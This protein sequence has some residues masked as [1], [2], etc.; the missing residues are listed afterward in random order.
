MRI[1]RSR[2]GGMARTP[3]DR[4][5]TPR[6]SGA[7]SVLRTPSPNR[8][9]R[10]AS[11]ESA[12]ALPNRDGQVDGE[13]QLNQENQ[14]ESPT[15]GNSYQH[16]SSL[17]ARKQR[18]S[19]KTCPPKRKHKKIFQREIGGNPKLPSRHSNQSLLSSKSIPCITIPEQPGFSRDKNFMPALHSW[20]GNYIPSL[21]PPTHFLWTNHTKSI[22]KRPIFKRVILHNNQGHPYTPQQHPG[23]QQQRNQ[24]QILNPF[25]QV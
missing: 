8:A 9:R 3:M 11:R 23:N 12:T 18:N 21:C 13:T 7:T 10:L 16:F 5:P 19:Q 1:T 22:H 20:N 4:P 25:P 17:H 6:T 15:D 2:G 24:S 14:P